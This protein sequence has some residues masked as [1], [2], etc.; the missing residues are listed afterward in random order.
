MFKRFHT[1]DILKFH[2]SILKTH[3]PNIIHGEAILDVKSFMK[4]ISSGSVLKVKY[5]DEE[6]S[7]AL[8]QKRNKGVDSSIHLRQP[9]FHNTAVERMYKVHDPK[10]SEIVVVRHAT[11]AR[12]AKLYYLRDQPNKAKSGYK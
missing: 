5:G 8:I 7:G 1:H 3:S 9:S 4:N 2:N 6:F 12:R 10:L 11:W